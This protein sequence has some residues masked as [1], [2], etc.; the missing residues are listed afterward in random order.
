M[1]ESVNMVKMFD[2]EF[3]VVM[4]SFFIKGLVKFDEIEKVVDVV[5]I[6]KE[7]VFELIFDGEF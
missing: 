4:F 3:C 1:I 5:K 6:V 2:I 7:K